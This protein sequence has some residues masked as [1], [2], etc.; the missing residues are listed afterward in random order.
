MTIAQETQSLRYTALSFAA[1]YVYTPRASQFLR[2]DLGLPAQ[3]AS[4]V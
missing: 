4:E 2:V 1:A 3:S